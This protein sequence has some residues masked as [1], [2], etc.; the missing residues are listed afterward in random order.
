[1]NVKLY[2]H[3]WLGYGQAVIAMSLARSLIIGAPSFILAD[4]VASIRAVPLIR[5]SID[6]TQRVILGGNT[7]AEAL[8]AEFDRSAADDSI[9]LNGKQL[10]LVRWPQHEAAAE[11]MADELHEAGPPRFHQW[12]SAAEY[13][14]HAAGSITHAGTQLFRVVL[15]GPPWRA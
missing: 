1:M 3:R 2:T 10:Q 8:N 12:F 13:A 4:S 9:P 15:A 14:E 5:T 6:E 11:T 7:R